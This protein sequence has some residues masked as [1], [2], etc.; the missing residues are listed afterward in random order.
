M[1]ERYLQGDRNKNL[2]LWRNFVFLGGSGTLFRGAIFVR[3]RSSNLW[4]DEKMG[5]PTMSVDYYVTCIPLT[6]V[7]GNLQFV[8]LC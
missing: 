4:G 7:S 1:S 2:Q 3:R 5:T 6:D 8:E